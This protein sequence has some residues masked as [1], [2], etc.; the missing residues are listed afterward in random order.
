MVALAV[1]PDTSDAP[2]NAVTKRSTQKVTKVSDRVARAVTAA[3]RELSG[4]PPSSERDREA[5]LEWYRE[6]QAQHRAG[7]R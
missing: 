5:L 3:F 2:R 6:R 1:T 4:D 7:V